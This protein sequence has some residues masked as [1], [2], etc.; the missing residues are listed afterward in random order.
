MSSP[1]SAR[2]PPLPIRIAG[3]IFGDE[4]VQLLG[5]R[6]RAHEGLE[7]LAHVVQSIAD[8]LFRLRANP[9]LGRLV[10]EHAGGGLDQEI[11]MAGKI[12]RQAELPRQHHGAA[13]DIVRQ[14]R[15]GMTA[16]EN[17]ALLR[18]PFAV[19]AAIVELDFVQPIVPVGEHMDVLDA[20]AIGD[21][22]RIPFAVTASARGRRAIWRKQSS[23][24]RHSR[25]IG[26]MLPPWRFRAGPSIAVWRCRP[27]AASP[28]P[29]S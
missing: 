21:G 13:C 15:R 27:R 22:H 26:R 28:R 5:D 6:A 12:G 19:A 20:D 3:F 29:R 11:V 17:F 25:S 4:E 10:V 7:H 8:F 14:Q 23:A 1:S 16:V 9:L 18:L 24:L 2:P